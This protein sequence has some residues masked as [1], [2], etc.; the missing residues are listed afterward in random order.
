MIEPILRY[1]QVRPPVAGQAEVKDLVHV[2]YCPGRCAAEGN[3]TSDPRETGAAGLLNEAQGN[4]TKQSQ[5]S[6][7]SPSTSVF[8]ISKITGAPE[9]LR[10]TGRPG[11]PPPELLNQEIKFPAEF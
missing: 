5:R 8:L 7:H 4:Q 1:E 2:R 9:L 3:T 11:S 10:V 6:L